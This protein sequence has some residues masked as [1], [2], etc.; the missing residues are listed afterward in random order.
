MPSLSPSGT[1]C[2]SA[3]A[4]ATSTGPAPASTGRLTDLAGSVGSAT[5]ASTCSSLD[6][7]NRRGPGFAVTPERQIGGVL[8]SSHRAGPPAGDRGVVRQPRTPHPADH[9]R[10]ARPQPGGSRLVGRSMVRIRADRPGPGVSVGASTGWPST[11]DTAATL[12]GSPVVLISTGSQGE[13]LS[14]LSRM[15]RR[16]PADNIRADDSVV[17]ASLLIPGTRTLCS[18]W[19]TACQASATVHPA[20]GGYVSGHASA[21]EL[22]CLYNAA[23]HQR[24]AGTREWRHHARQRRSGHR[25]RCGAGPVAWP[26]TAWLPTSSTVWLP[27]RARTVGYV[28]VDGLSVGDVGE[29][30]LSNAFGPRHGFTTITVAVDPETGRTVSPPEISAWFLRRSAALMTPPIS[31]AGP[32]TPCMPKG[33]PTHRIAQTIRRTVGRWVSE[34]Y[35]RRR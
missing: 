6:S 32:W 4:P 22:L 18:R 27:S 16:T 34:K 9:R 13:L 35:R 21:G 11:L 14:A 20:V 19:S 31:S 26:R 17:L 7:T 29:S 2:G 25:H 33:S 10:R 12:P 30:T 23:P 28:Y 8:D 5:R 24:D 3:P 1:R 15:A